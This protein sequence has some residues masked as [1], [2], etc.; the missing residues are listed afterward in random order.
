MAHVQNNA[1]VFLCIIDAN[2]G[3]WRLQLAAVSD[4]TAAFSVERCCIQDNNAVAA[5]RF[6]CKAVLTENCKH[7]SLRS[8]RLIADKLGF[9]QVGK[10]G[11]C[12]FIPTAD[13]G[14]C[15][16][17]AAALLLHELGEFLFVNAEPCLLCNLAC[18]IK[19]EAEGII[20]TESVFAADCGAV[21]FLSRI[22]Q[23]IQHAEPRINGLVKAL[24]LQRNHF[25]DMRFLFPQFRISVFIGFDDLFTD[26]GQKRMIDAE[27]LS[28]ASGA[29]QKSAQNI[30]SA[31]IGRQHA[32]ADHKGRGAHMV[33]YN[34]DGNIVGIVFA[35]CFLGNGGD[36]IDDAPCGVHLKHVIHTLHHAGKTVQPHARIDILVRQL[37]VN[38]VSFVVEL[39]KD[40]VPNLHEA[41]AIAA[42]AAIGGAAAVFFTAVEI[43][44]GA[45]A[46]GAGAVFPKVIFFSQTHDAL[47][48]YADL[49][50]PNCECL[51]VF[52][53]DARPK[54]LGGNLERI[55]QKFPCPG[56]CLMLEIISEGEISEHFKIGAVT[57]RVPDTFKVRRADAFLAGCDASARRLNLTRKEFFHRRHAGIDQQQRFIA[58]RHQRKAFQAQMPLA[59]KKREVHFAQFIQP[60][61]LHSFRFLS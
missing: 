26:L 2:R 40:I 50:A 56:D 15:F 24:F 43:N 39:G 13:V 6:L 49:V 60:G 36:Q 20:Q 58:L 31:L 27:Q 8:G 44:F 37:F 48:G 5:I 7:F 52:F 35:V 61:P 4:L 32:V 28:V 46:A 21:F 57:R 19:R 22:D 29:A 33:R 11:F 16:S 9:G 45:G 42:G 12:R 14:S 10:L 47:R 41:V 25:F 53:I 55:R 17:G 18:Q 54:Q 38:A 34:A 3:I 1:I 23:G 51:F 30:A 59:F